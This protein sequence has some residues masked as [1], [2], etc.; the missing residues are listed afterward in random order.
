MSFFLESLRKI[1]W[2]DETEF[3]KG[4]EKG[5]TM[6]FSICGC[7][8]Y[9]VRILLH[10]LIWIGRWI[11]LTRGPTKW[12]CEREV[13]FKLGRVH[14]RLLFQF[15]F[16]KKRAGVE[17]QSLNSKCQCYRSI[18]RAS[19]VIC[20]F[21]RVIKKLADVFSQRHT[22]QKLWSHSDSLCQVKWRSLVRRFLIGC[23]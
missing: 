12:T 8:P 7:N 13:I 19:H 11:D 23:V 17:N 20:P 1:G 2:A 15:V 18:F 4:I 14:F 22:F 5:F 3:Q 16:S 21:K 9:H 6:V 10:R